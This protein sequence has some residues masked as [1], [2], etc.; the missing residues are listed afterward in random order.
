[1]RATICPKFV[2]PALRASAKIAS[3]TV[4]S[5]RAAT[6]I[7][8]LDPI[9]PNG[10][11][12]SRPASA[13]KNVPSSRRYTTTRRSPTLSNGSGAATIG[14]RNV[15]PTTLAK[16]TN[17]ATWNS[18]E[19]LFETTTSFLKSFRSSRYGCQTGA[20]RLFC[21]RAFIHRINPTRPGAR[22]SATAA[23]VSSS[24]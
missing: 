18:H 5:A 19:A 16:I 9:P 17:G 1:V 14:T 2:E 13:R 24:T 6:V 20:P 10:E 3:A 21:S 4:G 7:S 23:C 11:P 8:R 22:R 15:T 12:G